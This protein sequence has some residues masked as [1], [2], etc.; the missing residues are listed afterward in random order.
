MVRTDKF[1]L[2]TIFA[3][4]TQKTLGGGNRRQEEKTGRKMKRRR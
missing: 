4:N 3:K 1:T 2:I